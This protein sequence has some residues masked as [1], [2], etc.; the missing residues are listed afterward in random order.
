MRAVFL[1]RDG[2]LN[3]PVWNPATGEYES[4][5][6]LTDVRLCPD[7]VPAL[8]QLSGHG[9]E[10]FIVSNQPSAAKGKLPKQELEAIANDIEAQFA[11]QAVYFR[12]T[13]YCYHHPEGSVPQY[14]GRCACRKPSPFFLFQAAEQYDIDLSES[15]MLGDRA[16][17]V[18]CG[19]SAGCRTILI[20]HPQ[21]RHSPAPGEPDYA[22]SD[23]L[24]ATNFIVA[25]D[26]PGRTMPSLLAP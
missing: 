21:A 7:V 14:T 10:L 23:L 8:H 20:K 26:F 16:T 11:R 12:A 15:W 3:E 24:E 4:P 25:H 22:A 17:D 5:H 6:R 2:V 18:E 9:F 19:K 1:D 13:Y